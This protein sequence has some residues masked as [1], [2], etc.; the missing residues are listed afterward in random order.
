MSVVAKSML[1]CMSLTCEVDD[2]GL[3]EGHAL[4]LY[5]YITDDAEGDG[6]VLT[7]YIPAHE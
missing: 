3:C 5:V 1:A 4:V 2:I 7:Y 6:P